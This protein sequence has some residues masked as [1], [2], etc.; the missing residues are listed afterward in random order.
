M[1]GQKARTKGNGSPAGVISKAKRP[2]ASAN[3]ATQLTCCFVEDDACARVPRNLR[4]GRINPSILFN[5]RKLCGSYGSSGDLLRKRKFTTRRV[6]RTRSRAGPREPQTPDYSDRPRHRSRDQSP[7][8]RS[9][10]ALV[11]LR[12]L[13][14][15]NRRRA[16][17][18]QQESSAGGT[19]RRKPRAFLRIHRVNAIRWIAMIINHLILILRKQFRKV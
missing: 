9:K 10:Q 6:E 18:L 2:R 1:E 17:D 12:K 8:A 13:C 19:H 5:L 7:H 3:Y 14:M 11:S 15:A 4:R 16:G